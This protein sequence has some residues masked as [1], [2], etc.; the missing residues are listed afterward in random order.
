MKEK[1]LLSF[2]KK[3]KWFLFFGQK[4]VTLNYITAT[5]NIAIF[6][7]TGT[8]KTTS[9]CYP[10]L[11]NLIF[12]GCCGLILDVK[13]DYSDLSR[14]INYKKKRIRILGIKEDCEKFNLISNINSSKLKA[15][16]QDALYDYNCGT[17]SGYWGMN[18]L[19][20]TILLYELLKEL[21]P[22]NNPTLADLYYFL[23]NHDALKK[24]YLQ[25]NGLN[26]NGKQKIIER[27]YSDNFSIFNFD[28][29]SD[30]VNEQRT[31]QLS[32]ILKVLKP[33]YDDPLLR[34]HFCNNEYDVD[35]EDIIYNLKNSITVEIPNSKYNETATFCLKIIKS[36]FIDTIRNRSKYLLDFEGYGLKNFTFMLIDEYQQFINHASTPVNN[37]NNW[38]DISRGYG[39]INIIST[40]SIDSLIAKSNESHV[41]Q[42]IGNTRN[43]V[44]LSTNAQHS[45]NHINLISSNKIKNKLLFQE[46]DCAYFYVGKDQISRKGYCSLIYT[47]KSS[48]KFM[49]LY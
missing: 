1:I 29:K 48:L 26:S 22:Y 3:K 37:D 49:N 23:V 32:K 2:K 28:C 39:H 18:G 7:G 45:L 34:H 16:F 5:T 17:D 47:G 12:N 40:Q 44:H 14:N 33:F 36:S 15:F 43:I 13:G 4:E 25:I 38:F 31:W 41:Y 24:I 11:H 6:G 35:Y 21:I 8:G 20:D 10:L 9:I 42:L 27:V 46:E 19:E 30:S